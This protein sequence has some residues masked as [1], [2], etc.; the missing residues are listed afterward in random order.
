MGGGDAALAARG[1]IDHTH[2][3]RDHKT[4]VHPTFP[5]GTAQRGHLS[6]RSF[7]REAVRQRGGLSGHRAVHGIGDV[8]GKGD[9]F[10]VGG[11]G[12]FGGSGK[13]EQ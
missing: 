10:L 5:A 12:H 6:E 7:A 1:G 4:A 2:R 13:L 11:E 8:M 9:N 3:I